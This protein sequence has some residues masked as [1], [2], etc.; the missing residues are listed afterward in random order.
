VRTLRRGGAV[1]NPRL[2]G[3]GIA[4]LVILLDQISKPLMRDW[5]RAGDLDVTSFLSLV[6]AWNKGWVSAC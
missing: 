6:S 5:L 1:R 3:L 4:G 2:L